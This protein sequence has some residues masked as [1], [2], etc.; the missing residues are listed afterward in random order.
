M[1]FLKSSGETPHFTYMF[2]Y[3]WNLKKRVVTDGSLVVLCDDYFFRKKENWRKILSKC[4]VASGCKK[5]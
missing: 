5:C 2:D 4:A 3:S 1:G